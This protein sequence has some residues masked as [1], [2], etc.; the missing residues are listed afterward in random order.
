MESNMQ[1]TF[2]ENVEGNQCHNNVKRNELFSTKSDGP[3][4]RIGNL[5]YEANHN[6]NDESSISPGTED[7]Q[8]L[9]P[10]SNSAHQIKAINTT[11]QLGAGKAIRR[12]ARGRTVSGKV[13]RINNQ[14]NKGR[15][16]KKVIKKPSSKSRKVLKG[17]AKH[18]VK[19]LKVKKNKSAKITKRSKVARK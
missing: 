5:I 17:K 15:R 9:S 6:T 2:S 11:V 14:R 7:I 8:Q 16:S 18:T 13:K 3:F 19:R 1:P 4:F 10:I 12:V